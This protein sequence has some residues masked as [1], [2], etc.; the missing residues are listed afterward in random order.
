MEFLGRQSG[1]IQKFS[2][3]SDTLH[4]TSDGLGEMLKC[5]FGDMRT[6][7]VGR[8]IGP[9]NRAKTGSGNYMWIVTA[10]FQNFVA[11][12]MCVWVGWVVNQL[13]FS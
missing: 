1:G 11:Y 12:Y 13:L 5:D 8:T 2:L 7:V 9:V 6:L 10:A 3:G 4:T